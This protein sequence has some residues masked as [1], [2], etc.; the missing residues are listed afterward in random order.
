[1][2]SVPEAERRN[3]AVEPAP[4]IRQFTEADDTQH[5]QIYI[6][7][8]ESGEKMAF[9]ATTKVSVKSPPHS[10][11]GK[12]RNSESEELEETMPPEVDVECVSEEEEE[13]VEEV[14]NMIPENIQNP[15]EV[16]KD[17]DNLLVV[18][19]AVPEPVDAEDHELR[20]HYANYTKEQ[21]IEFLVKAKVFLQ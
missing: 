6:E 10:P 3:K 1:M 19:A 18:A 2:I 17:E 7:L 11:T 5:R 16:F 12:R 15:D 8:D 9:Q 21:L 4:L 20:E 13:V 14:D